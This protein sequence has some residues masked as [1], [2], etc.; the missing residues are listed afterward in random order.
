M[1]SPFIIHSMP[2]VTPPINSQNPSLPPPSG[3]PSQAEKYVHQLVQLID[4]DKVDIIQTDLSKFD[5]S[6]LQDHYGLELKEYR[7]EISH[8]KH[9]SN[10]RDSYVILFTNLKNISGLSSEKIILAYMHLDESQFTALK[11]SAL[12]QIERKERQLEQQRLKDALSPI[13]E[14]L[15]QMSNHNPLMHS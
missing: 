4:T 6:S 1:F 15:E 12:Q 2:D 14:V 8:S 13:D 11:Q 3:D 7:V 5:P 10:G 9:P